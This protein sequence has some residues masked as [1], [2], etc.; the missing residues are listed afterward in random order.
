MDN[1]LIVIPYAAKEG[2]TEEAVRHK[3]YRLTAALTSQLDTEA[4]IEITVDT[5]QGTN[6]NS[7]KLVKEL[8]SLPILT[9]EPQEGRNITLD[10]Y[11]EDKADRPL[12]ILSDYM[13][14]ES[15]IV[16]PEMEGKYYAEY[17]NDLTAQGLNRREATASAQ[18][19]AKDAASRYPSGFPDM[20]VL[21]HIFPGGKIKVNIVTGIIRPSQEGRSNATLVSRAWFVEREDGS[22]EIRMKLKDGLL[23]RLKLEQEDSDET[24]ER[25]GFELIGKAAKFLEA[26]PEWPKATRYEGGMAQDRPSWVER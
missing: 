22:L 6:V 18:R 13:Y 21:G 15:D 1:Q 24:R 11:S 10:L 26:N 12:H 14:E 4:A 7:L 8:R 19:M 23:E 5:N 16:D 25:V 3:L 17:L 2:D 20:A 9:L